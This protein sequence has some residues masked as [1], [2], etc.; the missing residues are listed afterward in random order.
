MT[1]A[2]KPVAGARRLEVVD[3]AIGE[4]FETC[5]CADAA[6]IDAA[7]TAAREAFPGWAALPAEDR[8][9][10]MVEL[11]E[12]MTAEVGELAHLLTREQGKPLAD[13][14]GEIFAAAAMI[15]YFAALALE[16]DVLCDDD[17]GYVVA[18]YAPLGVVAIVTPWNSPVL[19]LANK[20]G[21]ALRAG[22]TVVCKPAATTPLT[23][24]ALGL[25]CA[26]IFPPGVV[27]VVAD[28]N[29]LGDHLT[30]HPGIDK[31][32]FTGSTATGR[33]VMANAAA[34][35]KPVT[36]ELGGNDAAIVL[37]DADIESVA[38]QILWAAMRNAGQVCLATKRA[39]VPD[40][41]YDAMC[42]KLAELADAI[43]VGNGLADGIEM[44]PIQ[45]RAQY[46]KVRGFLEIAARDGT[47]VAGGTA[48]DG[49]G[50]FIAPTVVRDIAAD[51]PLVTDEQFGPILPVVRYSD[52]ESVIAHVNASPYGLGGT[53]WCGDEARGRQV[54]ARIE[55]GI[56]W[57][58]K[59]FDLGFDVPIGGV[60]QSGI[61]V[62]MGR[63]GLLAYTR[64]TVIN[65]GPRADAPV[66]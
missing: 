51:S 8:S 23:T 64:R 25:M 38:P 48:L 33:K 11:V 36:L 52:I 55:S 7:V 6:E 13:A 14:T 39:Y 43:T 37:D 31:I 59:Y 22:N 24:L 41:L 10:R 57:V 9:R 15:R 17:S 26:E 60:K 63:D 4:V 2:G 50:N 19:M 29:D 3:P 53:I 30:Q 54:A 34:G 62:E 61:G 44:G 28:A 66:G 40:A 18:H 56:V 47:I 27:N 21:P 20:L 16:D 35:L 45:N 46:D 58:N 12:R 42:A 5:A 32:A 65:A 49:P 1:I